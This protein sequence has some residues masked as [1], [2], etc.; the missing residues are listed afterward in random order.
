MNIGVS[1]RILGKTTRDAVRNKERCKRRRAPTQDPSTHLAHDVLELVHEERLEGVG[2]LLIHELER[3][4]L[5]RHA[6]LGIEAA[7]IR[8]TLEGEEDNPLQH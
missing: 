5:E 6:R 8:V 1:T 2:L 7:Q 3:D 4:L